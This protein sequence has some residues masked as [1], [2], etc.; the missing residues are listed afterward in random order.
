MSFSYYKKK[1][2]MII[3]EAIPKSIRNCL[4]LPDTPTKEEKKCEDDFEES[5]EFL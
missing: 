1:Y 5:Y 4:C 2:F 3:I